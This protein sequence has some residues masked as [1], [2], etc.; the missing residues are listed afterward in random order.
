MVFTTGWL[1][2][3]RCQPGERLLE[4]VKGARALPASQIVQRIV[5]AVSEHRGGYPP[6]DDMTVVAVKIAE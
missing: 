6:N 4:V 5:T 3:R 1:N 2:R